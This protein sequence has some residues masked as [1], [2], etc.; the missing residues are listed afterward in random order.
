MP[1]NN[2]NK[3]KAKVEKVEP[4]Q[5]KSQED[6]DYRN[7][8][9]NDSLNLHLGT[10]MQDKLM[11]PK[12]SPKLKDKTTWTTKDLKQGRKKGPIR[13]SDGTVILDYNGKPM[14]SSKDFQNE[15]DQF[16]NDQGQKEYGPWARKEDEKLIK[17][18]KSLGFTDKDIMY[19]S[20]PDLVNDKIKPIYTYDDGTA[21]SPYYKKPVQQILPYTDSTDNKMLNDFNKD[22]SV[23]IQKTNPVNTVKDSTNF[24][25]TKPV[26]SPNIQKYSSAKQLQLQGKPSGYVNE[27]NKKGRVEVKAN[28]GWLDN[29]P[30]TNTKK[31][32]NG[33]LLKRADGSY[34]RPGLWDNIRANKGSGKAPTKQ[35]LEQ[36]KKIKNKY[37]EGG[38]VDGLDNKVKFKNGGTTNTSKLNLPVIPKSQ[39]EAESLLDN[40]EYQKQQWRNNLPAPI[41]K[42]QWNKRKL[43]SGK[44]EE[45]TSPLDFIP[46]LDVAGLT[47]KGAG[48]LTKG[49]LKTL[50]N[51]KQE[52]LYKG[53]NPVGYGAK[54]KIKDFIPNTIKYTLKPDEKITDIGLKLSS[55]SL[56][57]AKDLK[58]AKI[59]FNNSKKLTEEEFKAL[60]MEEA[61]ELYS[62]KQVKEIISKGEN[63][64][65]AFRIGLGLEQKNNTFNKIS[66]DLYR[67]NPEKFNPSKGHLVS[68]DND[69][70]TFLQKESVYSGEHPGVKLMEKYNKVTSP[71][72]KTPYGEYSINDITN[73]LKKPGDKVKPWQQSRIV[74]KSKNPKFENSIYD[75]DQNG[76]MGSFRWDVKK[77]PEGHLHYQSNDRW[78]INPWENRGKINVK[79][80]ELDDALRTKHFK[81]PLQNV[82]ML[83]L[84]GGKPFNIQ[85]NFIVNPS[86]YSVVKKYNKGG[87]L[88][89]KN[90]WLDNL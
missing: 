78:D 63:R 36:E 52:T 82:E 59:K 44:V 43:A 68:L 14:I 24:E 61:F 4:Y 37:E 42:E 76:I 45:S 53:I 26:E 81:S 3:S 2:K 67:I 57:T 79:N 40:K 1:E 87:W 80:D 77:T 69:I 70:N 27:G 28:G 65:D 49:A 56:N 58:K 30:N 88:D 51:L 32:G 50:K 31:Y 47:F 16:H 17:Y 90:N 48:M 8:M 19:H 29:L 54:E 7:N 6:F 71:T 23:V 21:F 33:G 86:D 55:S 66:D 35:M 62:P 20:S 84:M 64:S 13:M 85:N 83:K 15:Y 9:Y 10:L 41:T 75:A 22:T 46:A 12:S 5:P 89:K 39:Q 73:Y 72:I 34:S 18:Y 25:K 60:P 38:W 74:E 11:G